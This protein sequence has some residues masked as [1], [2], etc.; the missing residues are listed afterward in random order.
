MNILRVILSMDPSWGGP[1][2]GIRDSIAELNKLA[3][4]NEVVSLDDPEAAFLGKDPFIIHAL[5]PT[6]ST[7]AYSSKL[8]NWLCNNL[9][10]FDVVITHGVWH[11]HSYAVN[12]AIQRITN[13]LSKT[14]SGKDSVPKF[15]IMPHGMLDPWFQRAR[16]RKLKALRNWI[17]WKLIESYVINQA[18][19]LLFTCEEELRLARQPFK[20]YYPKKEINIGYGIKQIP[21]F[22]PG[23]YKAFIEKCP[24]LGNYPYFLYLSRIHEKKGVD[25]LI[26]AYFELIK[27]YLKT[28]EAIPRLVIAGPGLETP[29]GQCMQK[30]VS[31]LTGAQSYIFFTGMLTDDSK[32]G[33]FYGCE[34][35]ILPSHQENFG[36]AVV[37]ALA[38]SK[39]VLISDQVNIWREIKTAGGGIVV[40]DSQKDIEKA[41]QDWLNLSID[42]KKRMAHQA[43]SVFAEKFDI[44]PAAIRL[45]NVLKE[46]E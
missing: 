15:F 17:Y 37:E 42:N 24:E 5:G 31:T 25:I 6:F 27:Q 26:K 20:P 4:Y 23:M 13:K 39:P 21:A 43:F 33:A 16:S 29:Y 38:C 44:A 46:P 2:Q 1:C 14:A 35:F 22:S 28:D 32:W 36:I 45:L 19:G 40:T 9:N 3:V 34:A 11:Y 18:N 8:L 7:W 30:L 41:L 10:R 12:K